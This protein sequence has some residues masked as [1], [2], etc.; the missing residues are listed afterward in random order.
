MT[1]HRQ[2]H[3]APITDRSDVFRLRALFCERQAREYWTSK[4]DWEVLA[5]ECHTTAYLAARMNGKS[6]KI[7]VARHVDSLWRNRQLPTTEDRTDAWRRCADDPAMLLHLIACRWGR[8]SSWSSTAPGSCISALDA[9]SVNEANVSP[10]AWSANS[11]LPPRK[12]VE[13]RTQVVR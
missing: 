11:K 10:D 12:A 4:Q 6:S 1:L 2:I 13:V 5:I 9:T 7:D 8:R 3:N